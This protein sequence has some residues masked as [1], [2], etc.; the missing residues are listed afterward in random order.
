MYEHNTPMARELL[1]T[2]RKNGKV[3]VYTCV[4]ITFDRLLQSM[5]W[6]RERDFNRKEII[7]S[8]K[9]SRR[10]IDGYIYEVVK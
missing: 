8:Q 1:N 5:N 2:L 4:Q 6:K 3:E 9:G 10:D 7:L